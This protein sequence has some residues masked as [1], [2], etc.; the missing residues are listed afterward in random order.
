MYNSLRTQI[1]FEDTALIIFPEHNKEINY[2]GLLYLDEYLVR[3]LKKNVYIMTC[4]KTVAQSVA[5]FTSKYHFVQYCSE[6]E[7]ESL[8]S[9]YGLIN[10]EFNLTIVSLKWPTVRNG[11]YLVGAK[12]TSLEMVIAIG[13]YFLIPY[14]KISKKISY[15]GD[16]VEIHKLISEGY[17]A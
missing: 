12:N 13:I 3:N 7:M 17:N 9:L 8:L 2:Y 11:E 4:D 5:L 10:F 14:K 1:N 6:K 15:N 16:D